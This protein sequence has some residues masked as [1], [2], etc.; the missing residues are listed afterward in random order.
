MLIDCEQ[1]AMKDTS[2]CEDCLVTCLLDA[3]PLEVGDSFV[4]AVE[5]LAHEGLVSELRHIPARRRI[6]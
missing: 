3:G 1:C 5:N 6:S 2:A 4:T